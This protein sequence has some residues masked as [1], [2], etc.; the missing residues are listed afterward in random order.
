MEKLKD[1]WET[2]LKC[3]MNASF[4][5]GSYQPSTLP[6]RIAMTSINERLNGG[7][8]VSSATTDTPKYHQRNWQGNGT[9]GFELRRTL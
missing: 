9:L 3:T 6:R 5:T 7:P 4:V 2:Y 1:N 8:A